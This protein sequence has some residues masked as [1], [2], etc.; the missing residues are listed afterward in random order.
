M[1]ETKAM[2]VAL[3][4]WKAMRKNTLRGFAKVRVG[5]A[6]ILHDVG[7]HCSEGKRWASPAS[8]PQVDKDG[9]AMRDDKGKI[10]Y[11]PIVEWLDRD[12]RDAF[13][14][15]VIAAV[16]AAHPGDTTGAA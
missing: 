10:K 1:S 11:V 4:G 12:A 5:R 6:L 14:E 16:E 15:G 7:V 2:P 13:F 3:L 8:K 9:N